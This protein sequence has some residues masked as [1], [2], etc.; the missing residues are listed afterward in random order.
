ML[1]GASEWVHSIL[2]WCTFW[3]QCWH[4]HMY[5]ISVCIEIIYVQKAQLWP[6]KHE[7]MLTSTHIHH[8]SVCIEVNICSEDTVWPK[9]NMLCKSILYESPTWYC[10]II[11]GLR[12]RTRVILQS[13]CKPYSA[14]LSL[15]CGLQWTL[16]LYLTRTLR[17]LLRIASWRDLDKSLREIYDKVS[18]HW[19]RSV[20]LL[21]GVPT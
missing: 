4:S 5:I 11:G 8:L 16:H 13:L 17:F 3:R 18:P 14:L 9:K 7:N 6:R 10:L 2:I 19:P 21:W 15:V 12:S 1:C 20:L